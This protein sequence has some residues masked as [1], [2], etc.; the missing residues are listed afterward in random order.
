MDQ[1]SLKIAELINKAEVTSVVNSYFRA[2][3]EKNF[4]AQHFVSIFTAEAKMTR[5]NGASWSDPQKSAQAMRKAS[6]ALKDRNI[7]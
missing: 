3:D 2:L 1:D 6:R 7:F 5:P 4:D